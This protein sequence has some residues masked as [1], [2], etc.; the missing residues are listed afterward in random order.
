[1]GSG[2]RIDAFGI[3]SDGSSIDRM[4]GLI[5][6]SITSSDGSAIDVGRMEGLKETS[7]F[8]NNEVAVDG[9]H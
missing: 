2:G 8:A 1:M 7:G 6:T 5:Q 4:G 9:E 3:S